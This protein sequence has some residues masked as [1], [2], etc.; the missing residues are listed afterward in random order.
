MDYGKDCTYEHILVALT[1]GAQKSARR[2]EAMNTL[3]QETE[4]KARNNF[5]RTVR[6]GDIK[7]K[8]PKNVKAPLQHLS[9]TRVSSS[10]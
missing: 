8:L 10:G 1:M 6:F 3:H 2:D 9:H 7:G 5:A 4:E